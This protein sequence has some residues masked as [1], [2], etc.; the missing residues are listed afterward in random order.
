MSDAP[1]PLECNRRPLSVHMV[2]LDVTAAALLVT[3]EAPVTSRE[4]P[5]PSLLSSEWRAPCGSEHSCEALCGLWPAAGDDQ[6][7]VWR[8]SAGWRRPLR[9][10]KGECALHVF[11]FLQEG[12][13]PTHH[14]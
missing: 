1:C 14:F 6:C 11:W 10:D 9:Q 12:T 8:A 7:V 4:S 13:R 3:T 5:F 2:H